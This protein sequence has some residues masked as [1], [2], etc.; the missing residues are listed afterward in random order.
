MKKIKMELMKPTQ[1]KIKNTG[2]SLS[3]S[4][5]LCTTLSYILSLHMLQ[6][7]YFEREMEK[8]FV[9]TNQLGK[10]K[11]YN[12]YWFFSSDGRIF[13][14]SSDS[15]LWGYYSSKDEVIM[16]TTNHKCQQASFNLCL[17]D[18]TSLLSLNSLMH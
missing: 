9:R 4:V 14:E 7:Q 13:V 11:N 8:R 12:R 18:N 6:K 5:S 16:L 15:K 2:Y 10:D 17:C 1:R 3:L